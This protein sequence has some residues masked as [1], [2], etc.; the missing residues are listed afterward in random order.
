MCSPQSWHSMI[1]M[2]C[3]VSY[4]QILIL[5]VSS[6]VRQ[7]DFVCESSLFVYYNLKKNAFSNHLLSNC[8]MQETA[9]DILGHRM[10]YNSFRV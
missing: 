7:N 4:H 3:G 1:A 2:N 8:H 6:Y 9:A 5:I 10:M